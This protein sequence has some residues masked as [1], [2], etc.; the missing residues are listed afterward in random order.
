M[1]KA[2]ITIGAFATDKTLD[3]ILRLLAAQGATIAVDRID[4][5]AA[6][7]SIRGAIGFFRTSSKPLPVEHHFDGDDEEAIEHQRRGARDH[8]PIAAPAPLVLDVDGFLGTMPSAGVDIRPPDLDANYRP[9]APASTELNGESDAQLLIVS[10]LETHKNSEIAAVAK[11][12]LRPVAARGLPI[13]GDREAELMRIA[14]NFA[15]YRSSHLAAAGAFLAKGKHT[16]FP[17]NSE[18]Y[19]AIGRAARPG[20]SADALK[21]A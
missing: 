12:L 7:S 1:T 10:Q 14:N 19:G 13:S 21:A 17:D 20:A 3:A 8:L 4:L 9:Y 18:F 16:R 11:N 2:P 15:G 6:G 5:D